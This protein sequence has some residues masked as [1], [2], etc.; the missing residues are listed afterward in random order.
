QTLKRFLPD[1]F[2]TVARYFQ[3]QRRFDRRFSVDTCGVIEPDQLDVQD[4]GDATGYEPTES[5]IFS[6]I[7]NSLRIDY[8]KY[9]FVDMGSGKGAVILY[10]SAFPFKKIIGVE[11]SSLLHR[12][13]ERNI[14]RFRTQ[15]M[16]CR[17]M[18]SLCTDVTNFE[19]PPEPTVLY[20]FNPFRGLALE[21]VVSNTRQSLKKYPRHIAIIY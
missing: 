18:M 10:A 15:I 3:P 8:Q 20:L 9:V 4:A 19:L 16:K 5:G 14:T 17:N 6:R 12:I 11:F 1:R 2:L 13:A 7:M 21:K